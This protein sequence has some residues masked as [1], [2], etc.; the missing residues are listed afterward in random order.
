MHS[1]SNIEIPDFDPASLS[2]LQRVKRRFY[3]LRNGALAGQLRQG[4]LAYRVN[5][6]LNIPQIKEIAAE[7]TEWGLTDNDRFALASELWN[8]KGTRESQLLAPMLVPVT[9]FTP[10]E[11]MK[12][13]AEAET[14]EVAD[15]L[16]HSLLRKLPFAG[17]LISDTLGETNAT[18][19]Q[20]YTALRL[21]LALLVAGRLP[22]PLKAP[23]KK[24]SENSLT[25]PLTASVA[26]QFLSELAFAEEEN[27]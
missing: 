15:H 18:T 2:P 14:S 5:F 20:R 25:E 24:A 7:T 4:G 11:A 27:Q 9:D 8:N 12:W 3:A 6:G 17:N 26:R 10:E 22:E 21:A 19:M 13:M 16:C 1:H 23:V